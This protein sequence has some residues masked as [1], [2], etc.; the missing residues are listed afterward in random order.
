MTEPELININELKRLIIEVS[1]VI[2]GTDPT[3]YGNEA[4]Q[5]KRKRIINLVERAILNGDDS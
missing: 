3:L 4:L 2:L 1:D 5:A